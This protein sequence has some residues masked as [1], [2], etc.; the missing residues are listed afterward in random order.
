MQQKIQVQ[1]PFLGFSLYFSSSCFRCE[2]ENLW[3][4]L[5]GDRRGEHLEDQVQ[6]SEHLPPHSRLLPK[7]QLLL[8]SSCDHH[9]Q[10][11]HGEVSG[12]VLSEKPMKVRIIS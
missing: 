1:P 5:S 9:Q 12:E 11:P 4:Q 6:L 3:R 10:E 7:Q 8:L 2:G